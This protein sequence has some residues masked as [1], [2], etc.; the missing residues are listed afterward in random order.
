[1]P[2]INIGL[3]NLNCYQYKTLVSLIIVIY[4]ILKAI[5][6]ICN[7]SSNL[8]DLTQFLKLLFPYIIGGYIKIYDLEFKNFWKFAGILFFILTIILEII[9]DY[10]SIYFNNYIWITIQTELSLQL[11]SLFPI[12]SSIG[13]IYLFKT[14][15]IYKRIINFISSSI[16]GI[17]LIHANKYIAPFLYNSIFKTNYY[18]QN[19]FFF[20]Y[21]I[22]AFKIF[23]I[24]LLIDIF[25]KYSIGLL[26][27]SIL[28]IVIKKLN[29][30]KSEK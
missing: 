27:E 26:I 22:N 14:I 11:Y 7:I 23:I 12:L 13:I 19:Y 25:K 4:Y 18:T 6:T 5:I 28:K 30:Y 17:Y 29:G 20:I 1:M 9:F 16:L 3:L 8:L 2:F 10:L 24:C 21:F 15:E